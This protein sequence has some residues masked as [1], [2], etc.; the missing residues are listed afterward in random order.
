M[1]DNAQA[2][3]ETPSVIENQD[4]NLEM[5]DTLGGPL[6]T[7]N[8]EELDD[9]F[10]KEKSNDTPA[11]DSVPSK[12]ETPP[13]EEVHSP[14]G[15]DVPPDAQGKGGG[16]DQ[17]PKPQQPVDQPDDEVAQ[18]RAEA[19]RMAELLQKHG[20]TTD[21][22]EPVQPSGTPETKPAP[23]V[24]PPATEAPKPG[25]IDFIGDLKVE[26]LI[27]SK[28]GL[29]KLLNQVH[30]QAVEQTMHSVP[31]L[32]NQVA[33]Q[34]IGVHLAVQDFYSG[35]GDLLAYKPFVGFVSAEV[36]KKNPTWPLPQVLQETAKQVRTRL[37][38]PQVQ[39]PAGQQQQQTPSQ[40]AR[41]P[42]APGLPGARSTPRQPSAPAER[43]LSEEIMDLL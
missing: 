40:P 27:E 33:Q 43:G 38:L 2:P 12:V 5:G 24:T 13:D 30:A 20:I 22:S 18:L 42:A 25:P 21:L 15:K 14:E 36:A 34:M 37:R 32:V 23:I 7:F 11:T 28:E 9:I 35:N 16:D 17:L 10:G 1:A 31:G 19:L 41:N 29:N 4:D 6:D 39:A 8:Q 26:D 3:V